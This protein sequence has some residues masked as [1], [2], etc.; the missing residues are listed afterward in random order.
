MR[1]RLL[2]AAVA[3][4]ALGASA[5]CTDDIA[6]RLAQRAAIINKASAK[7]E[8]LEEEARRIAIDNAEA[9]MV[10]A[11][12]IGGDPLPEYLKAKYLGNNDAR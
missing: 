11:H 3:C 5:C 2:A 6:Y 12:L 9:W 7:D 4:F 1:V 10:Q 8:T